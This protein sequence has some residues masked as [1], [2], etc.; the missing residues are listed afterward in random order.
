LHARVADITKRKD[1]EFS[2]LTFFIER[3]PVLA[4]YL[5]EKS[6]DVLEEEFLQYQITDFDL[7]ILESDRMDIAWYKIGGLKSSLTGGV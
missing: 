7:E 2:S 5:E 3:P 6:I 1:M 4:N